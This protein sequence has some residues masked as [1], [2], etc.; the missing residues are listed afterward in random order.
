MSD[1]VTPP[2]PE[3][4][5][6]P[7]QE[8]DEAAVANAAPAPVTPVVP[9]GTNATHLNAFL[10]DVADAELRLKIARGNLDTAV[11]NLQNHP[12]YVAPDEKPAQ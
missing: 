9:V 3:S 10:Q 2:A 11:N 8:A 12:D 1:Q 5:N 6:V 4:V 7:V